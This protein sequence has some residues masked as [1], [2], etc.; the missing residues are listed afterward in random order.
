MRGSAR[1]RRRLRLGRQRGCLAPAPAAPSG[2]QR[3]CMAPAPAAPALGSLGADARAAAP[4][5]TGPQPGRGGR[6]HR[7]RTHPYLWPATPAPTPVPRPATPAPRLPPND[8]YTVPRRDGVPAVEG[9]RHTAPGSSADATRLGRCDLSP[10]LAPAPRRGRAALRM[11]A[12][13]HPAHWSTVH[14]L[15]APCGRVLAVRT[16]VKC[17]SHCQRMMSIGLFLFSRDTPVLSAEVVGTC[18]VVGT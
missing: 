10:L 3:G 2:R 15:E 9:A 1:T 14:C 7:A 16:R 12:G 5:A 6:V 13:R 18:E 11:I 17:I 8:R 4:H